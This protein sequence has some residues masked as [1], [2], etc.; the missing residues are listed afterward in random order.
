L[1]KYC[2]GLALIALLSPFS[3][4]ADKHAFGVDDWTGLR[5]ARA[6]AVS[7]DGRSILYSAG[8]GVAK[9]TTS[10]EY[11]LVAPDG[12]NPR[13]L[14]LPENFSPSVSPAMARRSMA[15]SAKRSSNSLPSR[16]PRLWKI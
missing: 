12:T 2:A 10:E 4:A 6:V 16:S 7:P 9:G 1:K 15:L 8:S 14:I 5:S 11:W 3:R 13:K